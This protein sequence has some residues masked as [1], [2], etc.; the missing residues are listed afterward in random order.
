MADQPAVPVT[1]LSMIRRILGD[2][3]G[4]G[5][6]FIWSCKGAFLTAVAIRVLESARAQDDATFAISASA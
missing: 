5:R 1:Y 3:R 6:S 2:F 4:K